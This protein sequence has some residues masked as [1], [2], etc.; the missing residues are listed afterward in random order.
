MMPINQH[1]ID[2]MDPLRSLD[3]LHNLRQ[4]GGVMLFGGLVV[5]VALEIMLPVPG[6]RWNLARLRHAGHNLLLWVGG[7]I[8]A[9][10]VFGGSIW[11]L[12]QLVQVSRIGVLNLLILPVWLHAALA[13]LLLDVSDYVF[14][15]MSHNVRWL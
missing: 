6:Y 11:Y 1:T 12:L 10:F 8:V 9:S 5:M 13:F 3:F 14:H 15:R 4:L 7:I 2:V